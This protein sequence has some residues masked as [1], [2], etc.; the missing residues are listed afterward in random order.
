ML[1]IV[2]EGIHLGALGLWC[3]ATLAV[4]AA[5][6]VAFP[7]M[8]DLDP[9]LPDFSQLPDGHWSIAA[10]QVMNPVFHLLDWASVV[11]SGISIA[12]LVIGAILGVVRLASVSGVLRTVALIGATG[13]LLI[14]A[15]V[16]RPE[17]DAQLAAY[18]QAGRAGDVETAFEH[19]DA[20]DALHPRASMLIATTLVLAALSYV[21]GAVNALHHPR[22]I[23]T[24]SDSPT[25]PGV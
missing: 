18:L 13:V 4:G 15:F 7:T 2:L 16:V 24:S 20:F 1:T 6:A 17:M 11:L 8:R 10:G 21:F 3:G 25:A 5:A 12:T 9:S 23:H 22:R 19:K 14:S